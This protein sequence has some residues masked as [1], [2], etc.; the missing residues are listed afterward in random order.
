MSTPL[1]SSPPAAPGQVARLS[2]WAVEH[3][4]WVAGLLALLV[5]LCAAAAGQLKFD[6]LPDVTNNQVLVLTRAPGLSPEEVERLV[7]RPIELA[8]GGSP[9]LIEQRSISRFGIAAVT[10]V[11]DEDVPAMLA[12]QVVQER[13]LGVPL[14]A[15]VDTPALGPLTGGLGEIF[16]VAFTSPR[17]TQREL[18][19]LAQYKVA[20]LLRGVAGV[21]EV[22]TW[23]GQERVLEV[24]AD[25]VRLAA[26]G[27]TLGEVA[28]AL[29]DSM[30]AVA[31]TA[32]PAGAGQALLRGLWR[33]A[34]ASELGQ[35]LVGRELTDAAE[36][37]ERPAG[38]G[39]PG[40]ATA[41]RRAVVRPIRAAE[42]AQVHEGAVP[43]L[44]AASRNGR[45]ETVYLM[46]QM[47]RGDNALQVMRGLHERMTQVRALLPPDVSVELIYDRSVLVQGTLRTV[48]EN[49]LI[50][51]LLVAGVLLSLL[52]SWRAGL[53]VAAAIPLSMLGAAAGMALLGVPG[54]L[55]SLGALDFGLLV[56]GSVVMVE[57]LFHRLPAGA[58]GDDTQG[59]TAWQA[60]I[61][62]AAAEVASPV[63]Y[64]VLIILLVYVPV[65]S[66]GGVE[67][68]MF[69]PM[70]VTVVL[71]LLTSLVLALTV[72]PAA[73]SWVLS[74]RDVAAVQARAPLL[75][76]LAARLYAPV[77]RQAMA[78]PRLVGGLAV[79]LLA[80][81]VALFLRAGSEFAPQLDEGDL[82][83]QTT[84]AP[85]ISLSAAVQEAG[86]LESV[87]L[88]A[89]PE[90]TQVVSRVG[91]PAVATDIMGLEQADVFVA[92][93]PRAQWRRGLSREALIAQMDQ[94]IG[95]RA[96]GGEPSFTQPIQMR[97]NEIL[98]GAVSDVVVSVYGDDLGEL[99]RLADQVAAACRNEPGVKDVK[100][101]A[102]P[103]VTLLD[104][105]PQPLAAAQAGLS[106]RE[107]LDAVQAL[108]TGLPVGVAY[109]GP[110]RVPVVLRLGLSLPSA[111]TLA[112]QTL[113]AP[114]GGLTTLGR[115]AEVAAHPA[116]SM[117]LR[118]NG[119]RRLLV[120]FNVRGVDL[121]S[122][123]RGAQ[124]RTR[125]IAL[126][127][128][129]R[130]L[131]GGQ[132][133]TL[134]AA[135]GRLV[136]LIPV[137]LLLIIALLWLLFRQL[138]PA[139]ILFTQVPFA[140]TGGMVALWA[141]G[142]PVSIAAAIGFIALSGIAVLNGV[143]LMATLRE[144][145]AQGLDAATAAGQAATTRLRPVL[146]TALVAALGF[147]PMTLAQGVGAEV[148][149]PL[150]TVV[151]GGL[152]TSTPL[153][154]IIL[155][156]LYP[157]LSRLGRRSPAAAPGG[158]VSSAA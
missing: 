49:L 58:L 105:R 54:N 71:A 35:V 76:R 132:Y 123:V 41:A 151:V 39:E 91:S 120:G 73:A 72:M 131:W 135:R 100:V 148:Q 70:A 89:F 48:G 60:A 18:L 82:V 147:V 128:G 21:V 15:G 106:V 97:F 44:G 136:L 145:E 129:Y 74:P 77:L 24:R 36:A 141:R 154:L 66:L 40:R 116:P 122:A 155:P 65:L 84:R 109:D 102:P 23:G 19:E 92:L 114:G 42:I 149:R 113:P 85:D 111:F 57:H 10:A 138:R 142:M 98:A 87:L 83:I 146:M 25:P 50:G 47:L 43:R 150:A 134:E 158:V 46:A 3:R 127:P 117:V 68:K 81:G 133:E 137:A 32:L 126:P 143:V 108:R 101:L 29:Q 2:A 96:P 52:G 75:F 53:L 17:R 78:R 88:D 157:L 31:G 22:N 93:R 56:D 59:R 28:R 139:V 13:L 55:M 30:G 140:C 9:G 152:L 156:S 62:A 125:A 1:P 26:R 110:V 14:P 112:D 6:A 130:L 115:V 38:A 61:R 86:R 104:V 33:P 45:G 51:G 4:G 64:S 67:G 16:H 119:E 8:L 27:L 11:F 99:R 118:H 144:L 7:T 90:V 63:L 153:T 80:V 103:E 121:G 95:E 37:S 69:R 94:V 12:R 20:P 79:A 34:T 107:V 5:A 124:A